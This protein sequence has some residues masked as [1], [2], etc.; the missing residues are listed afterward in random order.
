MRPGSANSCYRCLW[1]AQRN[2]AVASLAGASPVGFL[3]SFCTASRPERR[4][5]AMEAINAGASR[6]W[7]N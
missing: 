6:S 3:A 7:C 5:S 4:E 2:Q 1:I